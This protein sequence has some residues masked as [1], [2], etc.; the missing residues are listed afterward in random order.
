VGGSKRKGRAGSRLVLRPGRAS[1]TNLRRGEKGNG[2][3]GKPKKR[4]K[5]EGAEVV[6]TAVHLDKGEPPMI[7]KGDNRRKEGRKKEKTLAQ[8]KAHQ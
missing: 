8:Q 4:E 3:G 1:K 7:R 6:L 2:G 5:G